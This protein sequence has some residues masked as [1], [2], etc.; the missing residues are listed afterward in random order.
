MFKL[1]LKF[2]FRG[3][4][5]IQKH[6]RKLRKPFICIR[7]PFESHQASVLGSYRRT[8]HINL[9]YHCADMVKKSFYVNIATDKCITIL[10]LSSNLPLSIINPKQHKYFKKIS[11]YAGIRTPAS[12]MQNERSPPRIRRRSK[13]YKQPT[14][15]Y[16][17]RPNVNHTQLAPLPNPL[18][19]IRVPNYVFLRTSSPLLIY[20]QWYTRTLRSLGSLFPAVSTYNLHF[21]QQNHSSQDAPNPPPSSFAAHKTHLSSLLLLLKQ[22][23]AKQRPV[24]FSKSRHHHDTILKSRASHINVHNDDDEVAVVRYYTP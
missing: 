15:W 8:N 14:L 18:Q 10:C 13:S 11:A 5:S 19:N 21:I 1:W 20:V 6:K 7:A 16:R 4:Y 17:T 2:N 22:Q 3:K 12:T 9:F 24:W 23:Q